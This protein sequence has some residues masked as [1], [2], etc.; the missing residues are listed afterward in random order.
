ML[1]LGKALV[2]ILIARESRSLVEEQPLALPL[3][4]TRRR[5]EKGISVFWVLQVVLLMNK[6]DVSL[7]EMRHDI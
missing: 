3:R 1:A 7:L 5:T 4:R 2:P 6:R